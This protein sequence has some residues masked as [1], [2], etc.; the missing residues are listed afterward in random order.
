MQFGRYEISV[1]NHGN[2]RLDGGSMFGSVPKNLWS[3]LIPVDDENCIPLATRSL[4]LRGE[5]KVILIDVGNG[6]KWND[7]LRT[8]FGIE[9]TADDQLGFLK[10]EV[11]DIILT[12]LHF[13]HAGGISQI[14]SSGKLVPT[15]PE[16]KLYI[17]Q[18]NLE[19]ACNP[20]PREQASYLKDNIS[21]VDSED[22]IRLDGSVEVFPDIR[23]HR[24]DGHTRGQQYVEIRAGEQII[25]YPT[26]LC[27]TSRHIPL[28]YSMGYDICTETLL[29]EKQSF[30]KYAV[31]TGAIVF[32]E[33]DPDTE[34][35]TIGVNPKGQFAVKKSGRLEELLADS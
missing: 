21:L 23:V 22:T 33:H 5:G 10:E 14:D 13:D 27:P 15:Y 24:V 9:N 17:Q 35:A 4:L 20:S 34:A 32:F 31:D 1:H 18:A 25:L 29:R 12:H 2:F 28:A 8:I 3:R 7:K 26:D 6:D 19:N 30:M 16:A 11:T